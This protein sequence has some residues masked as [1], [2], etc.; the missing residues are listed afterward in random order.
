MI[1]RDF[2]WGFPLLV[3]VFASRTSTAFSLLLVS[4]RTLI[5]NSSRAFLRR[6][7]AP[8]ALYSYFFS[9]K[10]LADESFYE[11]EQRFKSLCELANIQTPSRIQALAW[12]VLMA[13]KDA[14]VAD[15]TGSGKTLAYLLPILQRI[16]NSSVPGQPQ[17]IV[18][19]PTAEL[20]DQV[21]SVLKKFRKTKSLVVTA[22]GKYQTAIRD[23]IRRLQREPVDI[24]VSTPGRLSTILRNKQAK[25]DLSNLKTVVLDEIDIFVL[26][27]ETFGPQLRTLGE[28]T[29]GKTQ[30][31]FVTAT[32]PDIVAER[33]KSEF[34]GVEEVRGPGL[35]RVAPTIEEILVDVSVPS[36]ENRNTNLGFDMKAKE[37]Q[38]SLRQNRFRKTL[39]F[40]N[41]VETCRKVEN[42]LKR[43]DR[44]GKLY[45]VRSY[46]NALVSTTRN[47]NLSK[48]LGPSEAD[49][50]LV[51][52]D[53][54]SRGVDFDVDHVIIFDF[55]GDPAE[56]IR[57]VGRVGRAGKQGRCTVFAYGWQ[58]PVARSIIGGKYDPTSS[59]VVLDN[60]IAGP[61]NKRTER[62]IRSSIAEGKD[63]L[64]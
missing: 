44:R 30:L 24:L 62:L 35:H 31:V 51:C 59:G 45:E 63:W 60:D 19:A 64:P 27:D 26:D 55:P 13:G 61:K 28:A 21:H 20:A 47:E 29:P 50:I 23:Q 41:T 8:T 18:L 22:T 57:R 33:V 43:N 1:G 14:I 4:P 52:T 42:L 7:L 11:D 54:A 25:L 16:E 38:K 58:L 2:W 10:S 9:Q 48:F 32:L 56:Y 36:D 46:H 15:Q 39:I 49:Q 34:P 17:A 12:P 6:S 37:L 5:K 53:R 40:C 3:A